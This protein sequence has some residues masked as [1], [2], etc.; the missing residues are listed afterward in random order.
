MDDKLRAKLSPA[1]V[2]E[3]ESLDRD[4]ASSGGSYRILVQL[5]HAFD[6]ATER[7]LHDAGATIQSS[8]GDIVT[9]R[10]ARARL[11]ELLALDDV[12][13]VELSRAL[14]LE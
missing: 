5:T 11:P 9:V 4:P 14:H 6:A 2:S 7:R 1:S 8:A 3:V 12:R 10:T 13:Y